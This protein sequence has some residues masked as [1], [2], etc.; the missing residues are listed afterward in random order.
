ME[1]GAIAC[2]AAAR[3]GTG[4]VPVPAWLPTAPGLPSALQAGLGE[5][6]QEEQGGPAR[7]PV[8]PPQPPCAPSL[9]VRP[10]VTR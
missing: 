3:W 9:E 7:W 10:R 4:P 5:R 2:L 6:A 8:S 1:P